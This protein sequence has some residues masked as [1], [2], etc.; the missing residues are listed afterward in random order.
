MQS[1]DTLYSLPVNWPAPGPSQCNGLYTPNSPITTQ[2]AY[3]PNKTHH[4]HV[5]ACL[6]ESSQPQLSKT[7][8]P[9]NAPPHTRHASHSAGTQNFPNGRRCLKQTPPMQHLPTPF[10]LPGHWFGV[11]VQ[12]Q[13][14]PT[15]SE[16]LFPTS[17][18]A[19]TISRHPYFRLKSEHLNPKTLLQAIPCPPTRLYN[20]VPTSIRATTSAPHH[21]TKVIYRQLQLRA[22]SSGC[23]ELGGWLHQPK[24]V[25]TDTQGR[26]ETEYMHSQLPSLLSRSKARASTVQN[27]SAFSFPKHQI[28]LNISK[29]LAAIS[30]NI[31]SAFS[32]PTPHTQPNISIQRTCCNSQDILSRFS[33]P[34]PPRPAKHLDFKHLAQSQTQA[35]HLSIQC[36]PVHPT[37]SYHCLHNAHHPSN[38]KQRHSSKQNASLKGLNDLKAGHRLI[39]SASSKSLT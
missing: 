8:H 16:R 18:R 36:A 31:D 2:G 15:R 23:R 9:E 39:Q 5:P 25:G 35:T 33:F 38:P 20:V 21:R 17:I 12:V 14:P 30:R 11:A 13:R 24:Q 6:P 1:T 34:K 22:H 3:T 7:Q 37:S 19:N 27:I 10:P 32:F 4:N 26:I 29:R 28:Q